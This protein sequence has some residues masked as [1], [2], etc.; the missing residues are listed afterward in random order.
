[1]AALMA[2]LKDWRTTVPGVAIS[3]ALMYLCPDLYKDLTT[4]GGIGTLVVALAPV[5]MGALS[6]GK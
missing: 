3:A 1:M 2:R 6:K 4:P 5:V